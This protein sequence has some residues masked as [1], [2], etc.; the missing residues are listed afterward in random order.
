MEKVIH[1]RTFYTPTGRKRVVEVRENSWGNYYRVMKWNHVPNKSKSL[2]K[3]YATYNSG[4]NFS[5]KAKAI[6]KAN[7]LAKK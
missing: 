3:A 7:S 2:I 5:N 1:S 6:K 4:Y